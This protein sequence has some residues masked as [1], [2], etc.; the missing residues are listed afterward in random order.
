MHIV[1]PIDIGKQPTRIA[2]GF[3]KPLKEAK[4]FLVNLFLSFS[5]F[6]VLDI[7]SDFGLI[8]TDG[9]HTVPST[10]EVVSPVGLL[11]E[12]RKTLEYLDG[13]L[14]FEYTHQFRYQDSL[15]ETESMRWI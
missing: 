7:L 3:K 8:Q 1:F 11:L 4:F 5:I 15:G 13:S 14:A 6:L 10:P 9:T 2:D 12:Q